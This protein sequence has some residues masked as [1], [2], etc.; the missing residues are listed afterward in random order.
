MY[1]HNSY[2]RLL[3][4]SNGLGV[5]GSQ[6]LSSKQRSPISLEVGLSLFYRELV[7]SEYS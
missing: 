7:S 6:A 4:V 3:M 1:T 5:E 2:P